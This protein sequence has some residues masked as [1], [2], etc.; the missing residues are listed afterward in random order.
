MNILTLLVLFCF[1]A[2]ALG[3]SSKKLSQGKSKDLAKWQITQSST[4]MAICLCFILVAYMNRIG[5]MVIS[6]NIRPIFVI[7]FILIFFLMILLT[8]FQIPWNIIGATKVKDAEDKTLEGISITSIVI[9]LLFSI[10]VLYLI[11]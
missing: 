4:L 7:S 6:D 5:P 10:W 2:V 3:I 1:S 8:I 11:F 9:G